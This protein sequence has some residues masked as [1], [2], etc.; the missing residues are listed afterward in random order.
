LPTPIVIVL[1]A[2]VVV[3]APII[4]AVVTTPIIAPVVWA[5]ILLVGARNP[6]DSTEP[7]SEWLEARDM[8]SM[9]CIATAGRA[10]CFIIFSPALHLRCMMLLSI[11][12]NAI[13]QIQVGTEMITEVASRMLHFLVGTAL[14][15]MATTAVC[16]MLS[17]MTCATPPC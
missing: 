1:A 15:T 10:M 4:A 6:D 17:S 2:V 3:I 13:P 14:S 11:V 12:L 9:R 5:A 16:D 7:I 8:A